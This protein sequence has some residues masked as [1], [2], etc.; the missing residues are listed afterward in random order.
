MS[1]EPRTPPEEP[2]SAEQRT[3]LE[4]RMVALG[5]AMRQARLMEV[6]AWERFLNIAPRTSELRKEAKHNPRGV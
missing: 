5:Q 1:A 2:T 6:D 4:D 3:P